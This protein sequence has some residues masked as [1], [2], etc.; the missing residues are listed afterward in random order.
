MRHTPKDPRIAMRGSPFMQW[1]KLLNACHPVPTLCKPGSN[2]AAGHTQPEDDHM[3][4]Y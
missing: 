3:R 2:T 1:R 4:L